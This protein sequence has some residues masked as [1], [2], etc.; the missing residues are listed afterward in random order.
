MLINEIVIVIELSWT[1]EL[2]WNVKKEIEVNALSIL[3]GH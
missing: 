3:Q 2:L 1:N